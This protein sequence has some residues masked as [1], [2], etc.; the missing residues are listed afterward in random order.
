[1]GP[2][3]R[4]RFPAVAD[5]FYPGSP[6]ELREAVESLLA[7]ALSGAAAT[8]PKAPP[9]TPPKAP[10]A[11]NAAQAPKAPK[12]RRAPKAIIAPHAGYAYS[13]PIA[14]SAF[15][16]LAPTLAPEP[17]APRRIVLLGPAHR[18]PVRGLA[19]PGVEAM[20]TPLGLVDLDEEAVAAVAALPQVR[21][22]P[23]AH[24]E[25]HSLEVELPFL[26]V[27]LPRWLVLPLVVGSA[28][29]DEV[30]EVLERV[31]GGPETT[32]VISSDLSHYLPA[33]EAERT[34]RETAERI[35][36]LDG[37]LAPERACGAAPINGL[38]LA[39]R[40]AGLA[41]ELLDL[42][43]SGDTAGDRTRVVGY[44]AF[45]FYPRPAELRPGAGTA[46][47]QA[48]MAGGDA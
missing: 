44:G 20:A 19:L 10:L 37:P 8:A 26:Q 22:S 25:E 31:W 13:G 15:A 9:S 1:M 16:A 32:I 23:E 34:D 35:L 4:V 24:E 3:G 47:A 17:G 5:L 12:A 29:P 2:G 40:R 48:E 43:H 36:A 18:V 28:A 45:G 14:A 46:W 38:L 27:L 11:A 30:A 42:R 6:G 41:P 7:G 21:V 39:A 33:A